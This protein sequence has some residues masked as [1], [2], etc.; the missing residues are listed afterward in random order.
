MT[1]TAHPRADVGLTQAL[2]EGYE[3]LRDEGGR[4]SA[5]GGGGGGALGLALFL[6]EGMAAWIRAGERAI[7]AAAPSRPLR[8]ERGLLEG[9]H[10][11]VVAVLAGMALSTYREAVS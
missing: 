9:V 7:P 10:G 4:G 2:T 1:G 6:R 11:E 5:R 3:V 8:P